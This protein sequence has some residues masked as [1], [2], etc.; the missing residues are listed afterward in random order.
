MPHGEDE[1]DTRILTTATAVSLP[2]HNATV[3]LTAT[4]TSAL[5]TSTENEENL[6]SDEVFDAAPS[7]RLL[8]LTDSVRRL[9]GGFHQ[10]SNSLQPDDEWVS[11]SSES[12]TPV[13]NHCYFVFLFDSLLDIYCFCCALFSLFVCFFLEPWQRQRRR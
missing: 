13:L 5:N 2:E 10:S 9:A 8:N 11:T 1:P 4:Q 6:L 3:C 12:G 7:Q